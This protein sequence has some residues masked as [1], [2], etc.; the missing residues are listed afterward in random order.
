MRNLPIL[1]A[2][3][4]VIAVMN[5]HAEKN[6]FTSDEMMTIAASR[7]LKSDDVCFVG[8]GAPSAA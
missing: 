3:G 6:E 5:S 2:Q 1:K 7:M 8:I 4:M